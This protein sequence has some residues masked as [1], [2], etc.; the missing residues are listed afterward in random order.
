M[1]KLFDHKKQAR[2]LSQGNSDSILDWKS[3]RGFVTV[4]IYK[5]Y[6][7]RYDASSLISD[8]LINCKQKLLV[9]LAFSPPFSTLREAEIP[10]ISN[11]LCQNWFDDDNIEILD[12]FLCAGFV[13][14][15]LI[16]I[17]KI[18]DGTS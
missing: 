6:Q 17:M 13:D 11:S 1:G 7:L 15:T 3:K 18:E 9:C 8:N 5:L 10:V 14:N 4:V 2:C 16:I 12:I